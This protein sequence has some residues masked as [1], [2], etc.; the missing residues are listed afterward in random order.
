MGEIYS[1]TKHVETVKEYFKIECPMRFNLANKECIRDRCALWMIKQ[2][3][4]A[5]NVQARV[6]GYVQT[7]H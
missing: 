2:R 6:Y 4:C 1:L 3:A 7:E 5:V